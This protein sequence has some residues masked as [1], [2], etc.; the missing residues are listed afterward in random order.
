M[1]KRET[2]GSQSSAVKVWV[3]REG[4]GK[5]FSRVGIRTCILSYIKCPLSKTCV[6]SPLKNK[7][8]SNI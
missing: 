8:K 7:G 5:R 3:D 1:N 2:Q 4:R 6:A